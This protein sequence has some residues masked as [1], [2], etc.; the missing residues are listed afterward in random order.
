M[1]MLTMILAAAPAAGE[2]ANKAAEAAAQPAPTLD[3]ISQVVDKPVETLTRWTDWGIQ[4]AQ[5]KGPAVLG[6]LVFLIVAWILSSSIRGVVVRLLTKAHVDI[7]LAKFFGNLAKWAMLV[8]AVIACL[9]TVGI[10]STSFAAVIGA[11]GLA[12]GLALQ[13]NL[14]NLASGVLLLIFRPFKV[15]DTVIVAGKTGTVDG[16]DLF[17]TNLDTDDNRRI[18]VPNSAVVG[19]VIENQTRHERR[20]VAMTVPVAGV[21]DVAKTEAVLRAAVNRVASSTDGALN[22]PA[23][24]VALAD[25]TPGVT[26]SIGVWAKTAKFMDVRQALL[27][28]VKR[29]VDEAGLQVAPPPLSEVKIVGM[30]DRG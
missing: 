1:S 9:E 7:T 3:P 8:V 11:A 29:A 25:I 12:I 14:G 22:D 26:W 30:P 16:I 6:A 5:E 10:K 17:T 23:P 15:G 27:R 2:A 24:A 28:E 13:G 20:C 21:A 4:W 19:G 18:I